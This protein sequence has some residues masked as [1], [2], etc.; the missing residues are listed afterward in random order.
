MRNERLCIYICITILDRC[1]NTYY[2]FR[3]CINTGHESLE[4]KHLYEYCYDLSVQAA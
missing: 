1:I 4:P 2:M 3:I